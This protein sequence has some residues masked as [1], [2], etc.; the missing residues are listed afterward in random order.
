MLLAINHDVRLPV[1]DV[2]CNIVFLD[3]VF[4][5]MRVKILLNV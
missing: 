5:V 4:D 1:K 2:I 3:G